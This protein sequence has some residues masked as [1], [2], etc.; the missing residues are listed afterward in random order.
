MDQWVR[1]VKP[2]IG[3]VATPVVGSTSRKLGQPLVLQKGRVTPL[4]AEL[5]RRMRR[6]ELARPAK[7]VVVERDIMVWVTRIAFWRA[8]GDFTCL[9]QPMIGLLPLWT[10]RDG[11]RNGLVILRGLS[12]ASVVV[13]AL[14]RSLR[15][16]SVTC[17]LYLETVPLVNA[18]YRPG[19]PHLLAR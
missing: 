2:Q 3:Q 11:G 9:A 7:V 15:C 6:I 10:A 12:G 14:D 1:R 18:D 19:S 13:E 17:G 4:A 16:G 5:R 8:T